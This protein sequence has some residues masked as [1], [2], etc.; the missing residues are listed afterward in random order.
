MNCDGEK[1][2]DVDC[3][4][5]CDFGRN[6][7]K[8]CGRQSH[9]DFRKKVRENGRTDT[10]HDTLIQSTPNDE[11]DVHPSALEATSSLLYKN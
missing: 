8:I 1:R 7:S 5:Y 2:V 10:T 6:L 11:Q 9:K 3:G 4:V